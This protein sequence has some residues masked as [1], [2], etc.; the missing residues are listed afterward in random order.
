M[1]ISKKNFWLFIIA[2]LGVV[3]ITLSVVLPLTFINATKKKLIKL[4]EDAP[5]S[6]ED[7]KERVV[8][9]T[10]LQHAYLAGPI[11][12]IHSYAEGVEEL[13]RPK[14]VEFTWEGGT[15]PYNVYL[16]EKEDYSDSFTYNVTEQKVSFT[17]LKIDTT[18][19]YKVM[20]GSDLVKEDSFL[21]SNEV[22]RNMYVSGITN[23]RDLGGY[24]VDG[25]VTKQGLIYRTGRLNECSTET[26]VNKI[27]EKGINTMLNEMKVKSEIDLR[28]VENNE[29]GALTEGVGVLGP[30]VHY[31]QCPMDY[32]YSFEGEFNAPSVRKVF[33]ILGNP[34]NYPTFFHC[35]IG[36]DRT[37]YIA[38]VINA[39]LGVSEGYLWRDYLFSNFG[40]IGS[41]R[42]ISTIENKYVKT[43]N[44]TPGNSLK[45][46]AEK[47]LLD[48]GVK[49]SEIDTL[50]SMMLA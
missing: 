25:G 35:S 40:N 42:S 46:K 6:F 29:V 45:E 34:D 49:Q 3:A 30:T 26:V 47:Y 50:R 19:Y 16:S 48:R 37:G 14:A 9:H 18:Y 41:K 13:S 21:T 8:L 27:N 23:V 17:N 36:T 38:W 4:N 5:T 31:Y 24:K 11:E 2:P 33:Q 10:D 20:S 1:K 7:G 44:N 32:N 12:D 43:I 28:V 39:V 22:I 15:S